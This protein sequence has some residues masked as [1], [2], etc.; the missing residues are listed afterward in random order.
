MQQNNES[1]VTQRVSRAVEDIPGAVPPMGGVPAEDAAPSRAH[2]AEHGVDELVEGISL[3]LRAAR[4][5][6]AA[7]D[8]EDGLPALE[9][10]AESAIEALQARQLTAPGGQVDVVFAERAGGVAREVS[11]ELVAVIHHALGRLDAT[12][13]AE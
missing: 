5:F 12:L 10:R 8:A 6:A 7:A 3:L 13:L 9:R 4:Q 1:N 2:G 11:G